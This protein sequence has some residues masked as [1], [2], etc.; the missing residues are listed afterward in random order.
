[1]NY[2]NDINHLKLAENIIQDPKIFILNFRQD[3]PK[4]CTAS[5]LLRHNLAIP[6]NNK[7]RIPRN[8]I[9]LNPFSTELFTPLDQNSLKK[10]LVGIDCS[11]KRTNEVFTKKLNGNNKRLPLLIPVNPTNY[12]K[13]GV[14]SSVEALSAALF[15]SG[16]NDLSL[17]ILNIFKWGP[18]FLQ[19]N[20]NALEDYA[21]SSN[22]IEMKAIEKSYF[23]Q[24]FSSN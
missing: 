9:V 8:S 7:F 3:D 20:K 18:H 23:G 5:K 13:V 2:Y 22:E 19:L 11:W 4:K 14:L 16:F 17:K 24:L 10:G 21:N 1:M 12:G 6:L 15:I